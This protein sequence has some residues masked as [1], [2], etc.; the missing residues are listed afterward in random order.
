MKTR[1]FTPSE[2]SLFCQSPVAALWN[3]LD[4]RKLFT[5][6]T[7]EPD[8]LNEILKKEGIRHEDE[9]IKIATLNGKKIINSIK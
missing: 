1:I 9:L 6:E 4:R 2:L 7:P 8:P 3:E 5:G